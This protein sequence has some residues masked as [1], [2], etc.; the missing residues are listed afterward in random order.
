MKIHFDANLANIIIAACFAVA[1]DHIPNCHVATVAIDVN[2]LTLGTDYTDRGSSIFLCN[3]SKFSFCE[4]E[5]NGYLN[6]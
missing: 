6:M 2:F 5:A 1:R 3:I 4:N